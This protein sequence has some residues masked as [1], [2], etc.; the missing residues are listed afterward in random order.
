MY[1]ISK[2]KKLSRNIIS[3]ID[4]LFTSESI[5][6]SEGQ[7]YPGVTPG[8]FFRG[9]IPHGCDT[10][11]KKCHSGGIPDAKNAFG[12]TFPAKKKPSMSLFCI[13]KNN[14]SV[15]VVTGVVKLSRS[16]V[17]IPSSVL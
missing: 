16:M 3:H 4:V 10:R 9:M 7:K 15:N 11:V 14:K 8:V 6:F 17:Q 12:V 5:S 2:A 13:D 1:Q